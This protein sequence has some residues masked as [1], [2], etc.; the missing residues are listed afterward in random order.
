MFDMYLFAGEQLSFEGRGSGGG[1]TSSFPFRTRSFTWKMK[2]EDN[3]SHL[4][5]AVVFSYVCIL[6]FL[7]QLHDCMRKVVYLTEKK[8]KNWQFWNF[9]P[10]TF[11]SPKGNT[12]CLLRENDLAHT[13]QSKRR[14]HAVVRRCQQRCVSEVLLMWRSVFTHLWRICNTLTRQVN[15]WLMVG[16]VVF[17]TS[18]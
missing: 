16:T 18:Y 1:G 4:L 6:K 2:T 7:C 8:N 3:I 9:V 14:T 12:H 13:K 10:P 15:D 5:D 17:P 11:T